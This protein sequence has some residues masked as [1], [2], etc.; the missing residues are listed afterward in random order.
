MASVDRRTNLAFSNQMEM[1]TFWL[2]DD[3]LYGINVFKILTIIRTPDRFIRMPGVHRSIVGNLNHQG[4]VIP[5]IDLAVRLE[6]LSP[7]HGQPMKDIVICEYNNSVQGFLVRQRHALLTRSWRDIKDPRARGLQEFGYLTAIAYDDAGQGIQI[8]N[9]EDMLNDMFRV[10]HRVADD[11]TRQGEHGALQQTRVMVVDD[12]KTA[13]MLAQSVLEQ[14]DVRHA[15]LPNAET[16]LAMLQDRALQEREGSF[17]LIISDIE[18][19]DMD[20]FTFTRTVKNDPRLADI[21]LVLHSSMSNE[22]TRFKAHEVGA[23][24]FIAKFKPD[25]LAQMVLQYLTKN[26]PDNRQ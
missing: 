24:D 9:V 7:D 16:A 14:M 19:P 26:Q 15:I 4:R 20:G 6:L 3:Q 5:I 23:D 25:A 1:L 11:L 18:M 8:L 21:P 10:D 2:P 17:G 13:R 12:S 22:A